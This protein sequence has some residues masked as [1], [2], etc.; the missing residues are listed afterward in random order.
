MSNLW[1]RIWSRL[2]RPAR[3][4][5]P[6]PPPYELLRGHVLRLLYLR[7]KLAGDVVELRAELARAHRPDGPPRRSESLRET[8]SRTQGELDEVDAL[9]RELHRG[10]LQAR[11]APQARTMP[12]GVERGDLLASAREWAWMAEAHD[13]VER[14]L[15]G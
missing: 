2:R 9:L 7:A 5:E 13:E 3:A 10:M 4:P 11:R 15:R 12:E 1:T 14:A 6:A 8:V